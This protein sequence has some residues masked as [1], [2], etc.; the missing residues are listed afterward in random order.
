MASSDTD[1]F[2]ELLVLADQFEAE[3]NFDIAEELRLEA[4]EYLPGG[5]GE[6]DFDDEDF[7]GIYDPIEE[8]YDHDYDW[9]DFYDDYY[10]VE[11]T[12]TDS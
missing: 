7:E 11:E 5:E 12:E 3:G 1:N 4:Q 6:G 10:D 2:I 8:W 9:D